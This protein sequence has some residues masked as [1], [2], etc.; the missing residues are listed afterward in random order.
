M[1]KSR[2]S[3][4]S[5]STTAE[6]METISPWT[7]EEQNILNNNLTL[8]PADSYSEF[9]RLALLLTNLPTKRLRDQKNNDSELTWEN[10]IKTTLTPRPKSE[11]IKRDSPSHSAKNSP[12]TPRSARI[13]SDS[14]IESPRYKKPTIQKPKQQQPLQQTDLEAL[15]SDID[16]I[17]ERL[18]TSVMS[19][20]KINFQDVNKFYTNYSSLMNM[21]AN[22][23]APSILP[24]M[25]TQ[26]IILKDSNEEPKFKP[27]L[28]PSYHV[29]STTGCVSFQVPHIPQQQE[30]LKQ[31]SKTPASLPPL[32][33]QQMHPQN[34]NYQQVFFSPTATIQ[35]NQLQQPKQ[36][37]QQIPQQNYVQ[38]QFVSMESNS[39]DPMQPSFAETYED[40]PQETGESFIN[41]GYNLTVSSLAQPH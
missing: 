40:F 26:P 3:Q 8:F 28:Q 1:S 9:K 39:M 21:T 27:I 16:N 32:Q 5:Q 24:Q 29:P 10:F 30:Q 12:R 23:A 22:F 41:G 38:P 34:P 35:T 19:C 36:I 25:L 17:L 33:L 31:K 7:D 6:I 13:N 2:Y 11:R 15:L 18:T 14:P 20:N 4:R 37:I